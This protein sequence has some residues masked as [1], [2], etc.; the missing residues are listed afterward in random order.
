MTS[1]SFGL[2]MSIG[3]RIIFR[4]Q[5]QNFYQ[6]LSLRISMANVGFFREIKT[7]NRKQYSV[8][9]FKTIPLL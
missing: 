2:Q 4:L 5:N 3:I 6:M 8:A 1:F 7:G 9:H